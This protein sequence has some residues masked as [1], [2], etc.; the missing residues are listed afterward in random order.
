MNAPLP[1]LAL[2]RKLLSRRS[3]SES[4]PF[5]RK[6][7]FEA[8]ATVELAMVNCRARLVVDISFRP[9]LVRVTVFIVPGAL[10]HLLVWL[11]NWFYS[12]V[13]MKLFFP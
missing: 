5:R 3:G 10:H 11:R 6:A 2:V 9:V 12:A 13:Y 4:L 1:R 7:L 8:M